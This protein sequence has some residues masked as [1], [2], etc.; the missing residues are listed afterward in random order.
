M[1]L[2]VPNCLRKRGCTTGVSYSGYTITD[3]LTLCG[4]PIF[5]ASSKLA[6]LREKQD[7]RIRA[8]IHNSKT[9]LTC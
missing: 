4:A 7:A 9:P 2:V 1:T 5:A 6:P 3:Y 8:I